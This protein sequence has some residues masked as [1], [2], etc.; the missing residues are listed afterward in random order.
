MSSP[1]EDA[2]RAAMLDDAARLPV[3]RAA[4]ASEPYQGLDRSG[5]PSLQELGRLEI[6]AFRRLSPR[7]RRWRE[8][9]DR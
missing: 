1:L 3:A 9:D 6:S 8:I 7:R 5:A 2:E 4:R